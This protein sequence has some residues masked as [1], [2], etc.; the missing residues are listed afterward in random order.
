MEQ[1][2][3]LTDDLAHIRLRFS[4]KG[5]GN[6][7]PTYLERPAVFVALA[8]RGKGKRVLRARCS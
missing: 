5:E 6:Y 7:P 4:Y 1:S 8:L 2:I 3:T